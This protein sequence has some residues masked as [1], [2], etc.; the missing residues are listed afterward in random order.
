MHGILRLFVFDC[1]W[2]LFFLIC[3]KYAKH[4]QVLFSVDT[5]LDRQGCKNSS[6]SIFEGQSIYAYDFLNS[7][8]LQDVHTHQEIYIFISKSFENIFFCQFLLYSPVILLCALLIL[9]LWRFAIVCLL[10]TTACSCERLSLANS[11]FSLLRLFLTFS[12][13]CDSL[14]LIS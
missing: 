4:T 3:R 12:F 8:L 10:L 7:I 1:G 11:G 13:S 6:I 9:I 2:I 14:N 5:L